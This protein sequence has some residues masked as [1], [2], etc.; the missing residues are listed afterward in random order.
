MPIT[1]PLCRLALGARSTSGNGFFRA[2][3]PPALT[4]PWPETSGA[5][6]PE[7]A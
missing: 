6:Q 7:A 2:D 3:M 1:E 5:Q 4:S